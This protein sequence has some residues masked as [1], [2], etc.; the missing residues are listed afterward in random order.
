MHFLQY[1]SILS[2][3][4]SCVGKCYMYKILTDKLLQKAEMLFGSEN[5]IK[6]DNDKII[7]FGKDESECSARIPDLVISVQTLEHIK[8][9]I[10]Y[11]SE[12]DIPITPR[13]CGTGVT[14]ASIPVFGGIILD[15]S[16]MNKI[17]DI[18]KSN[19]CAVVQ[20][21]IILKNLHTTVESEN[22]F[23]PPDPN[24][25]ESCSIGGNIAA[26][27]GGPRAMKYGIVR[28]YVWNLKTVFPNG[29]LADYSGRYNKVSTGYN[30]NHLLIGSEGTLGIIGEATLKLIPKPIATIDMLVP[31]EKFSDAAR[32]IPDLIHKSKCLAV[33]EFIDNQA[34]KYSEKFLNKKFE[35]SEIAEAQLLLQFDGDKIEE[36]NQ[37]IEKAGELLLSNKA[38]DI[39]IAED[40]KSKNK[41]WEMRRT[42]R[43]ALKHLGKNKISEDVV[44]PRNKITELL[45]GCKKVSQ[46]IQIKIVC[47]GHTGDGNVHVNIVQDDMPDNIWNNKKIEASEKIFKL[48]I[49]LGGSISGEHGIGIIKKKYLNWRLTNG[50]IE[51]MKSIKKSIDPKNILNPGKIFD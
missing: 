41:I 46:E 25:L 3:K 26:S 29:T 48:A 45:Q 18:D 8:T 28:D 5:I 4:F 32:I 40:I 33:C 11:A 24:S 1:F 2:L 22:L 30:L 9:A 43:D 47:Y 35:Y 15:I 51:I 49:S 17:I 7:T 44:V 12:N 50:E 13:G 20:P 21:G 16:G 37:E 27:A 36:I 42:L 38:L 6:S 10:C 39:F 19:F 23:F 31:F 34:I 14:G